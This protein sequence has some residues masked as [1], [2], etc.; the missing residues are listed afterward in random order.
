MSSFLQVVP[1]AEQ[2]PVCG[3]VR[4]RA[5]VIDSS[6]RLPAWSQL[7]APGG[8]TRE[9]VQ[10]YRVHLESRAIAPATEGGVHQWPGTNR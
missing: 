7:S 3:W 5:L 2:S 9:T 1:A 4:I 8:F 10:Q 6:R